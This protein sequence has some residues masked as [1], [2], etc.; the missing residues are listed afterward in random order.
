MTLRLKR[1][2]SPRSWPLPRKGTKWIK[3]VA[4]GPHAQDASVPLVLVLRDI[5][6]IANSA[7][8]VRI[9]LREGKVTLDGKVVK[10]P[11]RGVGLMDVLTLA[12]PQGQSY[13]MLRDRRGKLQLVKIAAAEAKFKIGRISS[14]HSVPGG[15]VA[16]TL[17]DGRNILVEPKSE[18][19]VGDSLRL[20]VPS[21]KVAQRLPL[22]TNMLVFIAGGSHVGELAKVDRIE[23]LSS[24]EPNRVHL[25]EGFST[26]KEYVY[27]VGSDTPLIQLPEGLGP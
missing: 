3:R 27:V 22:A 5:L 19:R 25:K 20:E 24:P 16:L 1:R 4:P 26:I 10:D 6:K 2:A 7:R 17:H 23:V 12:A 15:K 11:A 8:E 13:R 9:L 21:Q 18:Y 14:K